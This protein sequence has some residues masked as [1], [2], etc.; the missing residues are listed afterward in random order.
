MLRDMSDDLGFPHRDSDDAVIAVV[1]VIGLLT[2][3]GLVMWV[4][5]DAVTSH[6]LTGDAQIGIVG[7]G[8]LVAA[9][10]GWSLRD[11]PA[12]ARSRL[13]ADEIGVHLDSSG[14]ATYA[15]AE[16]AGFEVS[17]PHE[18]MGLP[19]AG[20]VMRLHDGQRISLDRLDHLGGDGRNSARAIAEI[21]ARVA[22]LNR[23]LDD[24]R[25][26]PSRASGQ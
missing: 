13:L 14:R 26:E 21:T 7:I 20:A 25:H 23:R 1:G 24:A 8:L 6:R 4:P 2:G 12:F 10:M 9:Y 16:I 11:L 17:G 19:C 22:T 3:V 5:I 15:W 18:V